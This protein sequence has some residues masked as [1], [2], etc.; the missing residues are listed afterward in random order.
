MDLATGE[1]K[2]REREK[3]AKGAIAYADG[4]FYLLGED[5]GNVVLIDA[6]PEG[7]QEHGRFALAPQTKIRKDKSHIWTH[8]VIADGKLFLR[9]QDHFYLL[10]REG[11]R[12]KFA[13]FAVFHF[14]VSLFA[15]SL[16][17]F[18]LRFLL[19]QL[20]LEEHPHWRSYGGIRSV[21]ASNSSSSFDCELFTGMSSI[22][23]PKFATQMKSP[24]SA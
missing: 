23:V 8:P 4:M 24:P 21:N 17:S 7:W 11:R 20:R 10:R 9:D 22:A 15:F 19:L 18:A 13:E 3:L 16:G 5:D 6:S 2:W 12:L 14:G 1:K